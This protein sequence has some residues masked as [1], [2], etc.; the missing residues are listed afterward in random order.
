MAVI[1]EDVA[2]LLEDGGFGSIG[3][4]IF[5]YQWGGTDKQTLVMRGPG[6]PSDLKDL[7]I[8]DAVQI[9]VRGSRNES[10]ANVNA[11]A[12]SIYKYMVGQAE[13]TTI[14]GCVYKGFEPTSNVAS[15][16][17][18]DNERHIFALNFDTFIGV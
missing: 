13:N 7:Y 11:L 6:T 9:L 15:I 12:D 16:G 8:N 18:D 2:K 4:D 1:V 3:T 10:P 17:A 5:G 14:N